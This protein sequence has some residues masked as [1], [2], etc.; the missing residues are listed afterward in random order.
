MSSASPP[1]TK[2]LSS[3]HTTTQTTD[4]ALSLLSLSLLSIS[5]SL[6][7]SS[8]RAV[9][10]RYI[11]R[12]S[13][14]PLVM[15]RVV[16]EVL[17]PFT[18]TVN[19]VVTYSGDLVFNGREFFPSSVTL[20]PRVEVNWGDMR[21]FFTLVMIDPDAPNPSDPHLREHLHWMVTDIPGAT[22]ASFGREVMQYEVPNPSTGIHRFVFALFRQKGREAV[23]MPPTLRD[24]FNT[25]RFT[26]ENDLGLPVA[27]V[28]FNC[29]RENA[30]RRRR[31][32]H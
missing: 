25:R 27:A 1:Y 30:C 22:D 4:P 31:T 3:V 23:V 29:Q 26:S 32:Y 6:F 28:Y 20:K 19:M 14:E 8:T 17:D 10:V 5:F 2:R 16:G 13:G 12:R 15:G 21:T 11:M 18:P 24:R 7:S 9:H